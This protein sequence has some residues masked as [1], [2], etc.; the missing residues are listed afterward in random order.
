MILTIRRVSPGK[1]WLTHARNSACAR[2]CEAEVG[3]DE[4]CLALSR[5]ID[6]AR[7]LSWITVETLWALRKIP[8]L[9]ERFLDSV[10]YTVGMSSRAL[11]TPMSW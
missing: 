6:R 9:H 8:I 7:D 5:G 4:R 2:A 10:G 11:L 3:R 1:H